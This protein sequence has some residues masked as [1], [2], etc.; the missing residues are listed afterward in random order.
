MTKIEI[1]IIKILTDIIFE[2]YDLKIFKDNRLNTQILYITIKT[3]TIINLIQENGT[4]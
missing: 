4:N 3:N 2:R 1:I